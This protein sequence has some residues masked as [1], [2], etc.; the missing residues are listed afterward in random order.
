MHLFEKDAATWSMRDPSENAIV[1]CVNE[2][3]YQLFGHARDPIPASPR[4]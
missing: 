2:K 4:Q 1:L 3:P